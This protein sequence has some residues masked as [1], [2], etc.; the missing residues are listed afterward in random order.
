MNSTT[1]SRF[2]LFA[3]AFVRKYW[4]TVKSG[5]FSMPP[6]EPVEET[7]E[8]LLSK[9]S[10]QM[11]PGSASVHDAHLFAFRM[12]NTHGDWWLFTFRDKGQAWE[13]VGAFARSDT[14]TPHD[15]LDSV[16]SRYF[17]PFLRHVERAANDAI[18]I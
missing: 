6:D 15:L 7:I 13:L 14:Q 11:E 2:E 17:E 1:H 4:E 10:H 16:Y 5:D 8:E 9:I 18:S 12:T 3:E